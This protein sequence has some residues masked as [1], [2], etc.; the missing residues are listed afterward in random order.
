MNSYMIEKWNETIDD[1]DYVYHLGDLGLGSREK[2]T[3]IVQSL[4]G[5]KTLITGNHDHGTITAYESMGFDK[6]IRQ[7]LRL[8]YEDK[9]I[10]LS[11]HPIDELEDWEYNVF[12]HIH[13]N[14]DEL[15]HRRGC[16]VCVERINYIPM[17]FS[18]V[19]KNLSIPAGENLT[20]V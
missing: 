11:H 9:T 8:T 20:F 2:L 6:V 3:P 19:L 10:W 13:T 12:G 14:H 7:P 17:E 16:C 5:K 18:E 4:N 1:D 15:I